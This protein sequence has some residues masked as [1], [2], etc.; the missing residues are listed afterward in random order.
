ML[1]VEEYNIK[2]TVCDILHTLSN[3]P[4]FAIISEMSIIRNGMFKSFGYPVSFIRITETPHEYLISG[5]L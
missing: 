5:P 1:S 3:F 2:I 4:F